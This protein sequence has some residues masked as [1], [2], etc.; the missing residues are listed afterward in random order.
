MEI[1]DGPVPFLPPFK[2]SDLSACQIAAIGFS[3]FCNP[4]FLN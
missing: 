4:L 2:S 3:A 1:A